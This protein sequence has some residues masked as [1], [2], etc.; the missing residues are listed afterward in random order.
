MR[1]TRDRQ[2]GFWDKP[3]G[4]GRCV[5]LRVD[6]TSLV[7]CRAT[8]QAILIISLSFSHRPQAEREPADEEKRK[9]PERKRKEEEERGRRRGAGGVT[10]LDAGG[11]AGLVEPEN[12]RDIWER[13]SVK[14][15][16]EARWSETVNHPGREEE[17]KREK[18]RKRKVKKREEKRSGIDYSPVVI[19]SNNRISSPGLI[20]CVQTKASRTSREER[21]KKR[22]NIKKERNQILR[23][24]N[25]AF[26][27][28]KIIHLPKHEVSQPRKKT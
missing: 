28:G 12:K 22:N 21:K 16:C 20:I 14:T 13:T 26:R 24:Q 10:S 7:Q 9:T 11:D 27:G 25:N 5:I 3:D 15:V 17:E 1:R 2:L 6:K 23:F 4:R 8:E 18:K 19:I